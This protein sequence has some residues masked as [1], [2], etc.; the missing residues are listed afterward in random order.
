[1]GKKTNDKLCIMIIPHTDKVKRLTIPSWLPKAI[2]IAI[3]LIFLSIVLVINSIRSSYEDLKEMYTAKTTEIDELKKENENKNAQINDLKAQTDKLYEKSVEI[4]NKL[5]E[6]DKLQRQLEKM[7]GIQSISRGDRIVKSSKMQAVD[8][9]DGLQVLMD[10]LDSKEKELQDFIADIEERFEYLETVPD[11]WPTTGRITSKFGTRKDPF[12]NETAF[13]EG[14]DIANSA[15]TNIVAAAKGTVTFSG[16]NSGYGRSIIINHGN[17][18]KTVYGH[19]S[20]LLVSTGDKV[21]KGQIIAKMGNT[22]RSTGPHLHFEVHKD[23]KLLNPLN[24]LK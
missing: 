16:Y 18:Y 24:I 13:H 4:D 21:E 6:I 1:V 20:K 23:G 22:G 9:L 12:T 8:S 11:L 17:G 15:G 5:A 10:T 3:A 14:I 2:L 19:V 7:A